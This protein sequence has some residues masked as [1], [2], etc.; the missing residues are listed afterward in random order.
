MCCEDDYGNGQVQPQQPTVDLRGGSLQLAITKPPYGQAIGLNFA[1]AGF[2]DGA[3]NIIVSEV[4]PA[5]ASIGLALQ[6]R[7]VGVNDKPITAESTPQ[8]L[9]SFIRGLPPGPFTLWIRPGPQHSAVAQGTAQAI[10]PIQ[11]IPATAMTQPVM[12][13]AMPVQPVQQAATNFCP[14]CGKPFGGGSFC[15]ECGAAVPS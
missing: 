12:V 8:R 11:A 14:Q 6:D 1:Q 15:G 5:A 2:A 3:A 9:I 10:M 4:G 7:I 13:T